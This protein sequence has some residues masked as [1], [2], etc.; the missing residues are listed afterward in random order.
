[1]QSNQ[2]T[3]PRNRLALT[4]SLQSRQLYIKTVS[5]A[6]TFL[7]TVIFILSSIQSCASF[8]HNGEPVFQ[9]GQ[10]LSVSN[11]GSFN[12]EN[13]ELNRALLFMKFLALT[14][15]ISISNELKIIKQFFPK[16]PI[17]F[18]IPEQ[19]ILQSSF[20]SFT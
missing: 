8:R 1:M 7:C 14:I 16:I 11:F 18:R 4:C 3:L 17:T 12:F 20:E 9:S 19:E 13:R 10:N 5:C 2:A 15:V 6:W